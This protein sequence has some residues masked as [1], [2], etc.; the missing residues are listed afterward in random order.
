[1]AFNGLNKRLTLLCDDGTLIELFSGDEQQAK[2][3][4]LWEI[5]AEV[6][7]SPRIVSE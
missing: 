7:K 2:A 1:M 5:A 3:I 4:E 6:G